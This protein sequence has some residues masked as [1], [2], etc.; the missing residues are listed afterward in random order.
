MHIA[1]MVTWCSNFHLHCPVE[2]VHAEIG[3][4]SLQKPA[5][6]CSCSE[7]ILSFMQ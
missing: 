6:Y 1:K 3:K 5:F 2:M 7:N 4:V